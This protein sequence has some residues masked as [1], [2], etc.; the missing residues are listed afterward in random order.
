MLWVGVRQGPEPTGG[1]PGLG[2]PREAP[3]QLSVLCPN[4]PPHPSSP[5]KKPW[6]WCDMVKL[7][8]FSGVT[9]LGGPRTSLKRLVFQQKMNSHA[10]WIIAEATHS[11][12]QAA[13]SH[14]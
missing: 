14:K 5:V 7:E 10:V 13:F 2:Q 1:L 4:S 12:R 11:D 3:Q 8:L 6:L 9:G